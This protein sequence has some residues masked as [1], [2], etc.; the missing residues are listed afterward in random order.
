MPRANVDLLLVA[1][2]EEPVVYELVH[3]HLYEPAAS[4]YNGQAE[5]ATLYFDAPPEQIP[6]LD[7]IITTVM[8]AMAEPIIANDGTMLRLKIWRATGEWYNSKWKVEAVIHASPFP[9]A[10]V[11]PLII[12]L[13]IVIGFAYI[14]HQ[15]KTMSWGAQAVMGMGIGLLIL[16][17]IAAMAFGGKKKV[18]GGS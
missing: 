4:A 14:T 18:E 15:V 16:I 12:A 17:V 1:E 5:V 7:L 2:G 13:L 3:E 10:I 6:G 9:W 11:I 8:E